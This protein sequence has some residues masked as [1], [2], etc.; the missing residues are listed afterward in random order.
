MKR[1]DDEKIEE[2]FET[3]FGAGV[4][5]HICFVAHK[6]T[7]LLVAACSLQDVGIMGPIVCWPNAPERYGIQIRGKWHVTF[8]WD[9]LS[10]AEQIRLERR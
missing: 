3:G 10:G 8:A 4:P 7:R 1:F 2:I 5:K 9:E 6:R